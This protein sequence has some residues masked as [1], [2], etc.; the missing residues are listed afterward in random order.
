MKWKCENLTHVKIDL[1]FVYP[2]YLRAYSVYTEMRERTCF[3][4]NVHSDTHVVN[5]MDS[6]Q[7]DIMDSATSYADLFIHPI[8]LEII[9]V[10]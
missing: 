8:I 4:I 6:E 3:E 9:L 2:V 5:H 7:C 1:I 10:D